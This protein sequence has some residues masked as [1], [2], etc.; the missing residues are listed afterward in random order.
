MWNVPYIGCFPPF[1]GSFY[2]NW[3]N[4]DII[5]SKSVQIMAKNVQ[6]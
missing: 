2:K 5:L 4:F 6:L 1:V 3:A